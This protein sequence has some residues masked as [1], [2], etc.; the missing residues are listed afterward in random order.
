MELSRAKRECILCSD[1]FVW[2]NIICVFSRYIMY[3]IH[4]KNIYTFTSYQ[5][6]YFVQSIN[7]SQLPGQNDIFLNIKWFAIYLQQL[8]TL[9]IYLWMRMPLTTNSW[10]KVE[11]FTLIFFYA[12]IMI[13]NFIFK[14]FKCNSLN[15]KIQHPMLSKVGKEKKLRQEI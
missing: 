15:S 14:H 1:Y 2:K 4:F 7:Q 11:T 9:L 5:K 12:K 13:S 6:H 10:L 3:W 8:F